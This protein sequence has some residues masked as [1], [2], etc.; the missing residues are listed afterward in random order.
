MNCCYKKPRSSKMTF[1]GSGERSIPNEFP[2][3]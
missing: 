2:C 3:R 1:S